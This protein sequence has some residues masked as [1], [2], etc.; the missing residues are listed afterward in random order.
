MLT[1]QL[2]E[3]YLHKMGNLLNETLIFEKANLKN[4]GILDFAV[5]QEKRFDDILKKL[6]ASN[7]ISDET[8]RS[9]KL[10]GTKP[11][12]MYGLC[13]VH[14]NVVSNCPPFQLISSAINTPTYK[15]AKICS[16]YFK[17][18]D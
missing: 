6:V 9:L 13:K 1:K 18:F 7:S 2:N 8:R 10:I 15:L 16:S 4:D 12:M 17:I 14:N 11:G 3:T 5:N